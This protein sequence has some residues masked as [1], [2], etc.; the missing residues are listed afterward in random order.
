LST[1]AYGARAA[2][3]PLQ[4]LTIERRAP[5]PRDVQID[6]A[7][8]GVCHSDPPP[9]P[10]EWAGTPYPCG[11]GARHVANGSRGGGLGEPRPGGRSVAGAWGTAERSSRRLW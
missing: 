3:Q 8:G 2:D 7:F 10:P 1:R 6:I 11:A 5:G 4:P 9:L